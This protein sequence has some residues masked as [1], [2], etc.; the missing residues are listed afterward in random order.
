MKD[1]TVTCIL[2]YCVRLTYV[3]GFIMVR[4]LYLKYSGNAEIATCSKP[5]YA[6]TC[7]SRL[8]YTCSEEVS[9]VLVKSGTF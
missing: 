3:N 4:W 1:E 5:L 2:T 6:A 9:Q 8:L 7:I